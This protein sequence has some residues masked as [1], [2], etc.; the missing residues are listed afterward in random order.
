MAL[1]L[2]WG[3]WAIAKD[4]TPES[5][6]DAI[7]TRVAETVAA[8]RTG[9]ARGAIRAIHGEGDKNGPVSVAVAASFVL[10]LGPSL[11]ALRLGGVACYATLMWQTHDL[12]RRADPAPT[13]AGWAAF[14][15]GLVPLVY[16]WSRLEHGEIYAAVWYLG[17]LQVMARGHLDWKRAVVLGAFAGLGVQTKLLFI[18]CI[19][20][21]GLWFLL[22]HARRR[23]RLAR[24]G[25]A[26]VVAALVCGW[27]LVL[28]WETVHRNLL[29]STCALF[30]PPPLFA[31]DSWLDSKLRQLRLY[32]WDIKGNSALLGGAAVSLY[33][34]RNDPGRPLRALLG[35]GSL[36]S[37]V[38][39]L[40]FDT[41]TR[42]VVPVLPPA[43]VLV[44]LGLVKLDALACR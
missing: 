12:A 14:L 23:G 31:A 39:L 2:P 29:R 28:G 18:V 41:G 20:P 34:K 8:V 1:L 11:F 24:L 5:P 44:A 25:L 19:V 37:L 36:L 4:D 35:I 3:L 16:G 17:C 43:A 40:A 15:C 32:F 13:T 26:V 33:L 6:A 22:G 7:G 27:W 9:D 21:P 10:L 30:R 38:L 42:Y